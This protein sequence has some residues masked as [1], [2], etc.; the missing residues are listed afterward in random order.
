MG[1]TRLTAAAL[2]VLVLGPADVDLSAQR[3]PLDY[4][5]WRGPNRDGSVPGFAIPEAWP[6]ALTLQW[7]VEVGEGYATPLLAGER[8]YVFSRRNGREVLSA[9]AVESGELLWQTGYP[10]E[11]E[12]VKA[13]AAHGSGPKATPLFHDGKIFT[14]GITGILSAFDAA[15]GTRLWQTPEPDEHPIFSAASSPAAYEGLVIAHPGNYGPL[16]AFDADTGDVRWSAP[17]NGF[18]A[19]PLVADVAGVRQVVSVLQD[20]IVGVRPDNG[21]VLWRHP[22]AGQG[23]SISPLAHNGLVIVSGFD[24]GV[25]AIRPSLEA[26]AWSTTVAWHAKDASMYVSHPVVV[27]DILYGFSRLARGQLF[28]LDARSGAVVWLGEPRAAENVAWARAGN[29]LILLFD[30]AELMV[31]PA[32]PLGVVPLRRYEVADSPTWAQPVLSG[33]RVLIKDTKSLRLWTVD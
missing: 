7:Q 5:Q 8:V 13:A 16:T 2:A 18:Y 26:G 32:S 29:A 15:T 22:W 27:D 1:V 12:P 33:N 31:A 24:T 25:L 14:L 19:S 17:G 28:A 9:I 23:G 11:F 20:S 3:S 6:E 10:V 4:T 21:A 30:G